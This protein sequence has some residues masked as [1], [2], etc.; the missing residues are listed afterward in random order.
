MMLDH[1]GEKEPVE[2]RA[3]RGGKLILLEPRRL[4]ARAAADRMAQ[5]VG[6]EVG[7]IVGLRMRLGSKIGRTTRVEVVISAKILSSS[8]L[9]R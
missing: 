4:A 3:A 5:N 2:L 6:G 1:V 8:S 9:T 7:G